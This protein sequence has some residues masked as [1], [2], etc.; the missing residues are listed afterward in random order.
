MDVR[1]E[2]C[3]TEYELDASRLKPG[4]VTVKCTACG[5]MFKVRK[6][7]AT[8][9]GPPPG[10]GEEE[11]TWLVRL[12]DGE[13]KTCRELATLQQ[14]IVAREVGRSAEI[15]RTGKKWKKLGE[16]EELAEL[17]VVAEEARRRRASSQ[18]IATSPP[19]GEDDDDAHP[20]QQWDRVGGP[21]QRRPST[22]H[23]RLVPSRDSGAHRAQPARASTSPP[24]APPEASRSGRRRSQAPEGD[25]PVAPEKPIS[26]SATTRGIG[27]PEPSVLRKRPATLSSAPPASGTPEAPPQAQAG[28]L[29]PPAQVVQRAESSRPSAPNK[30]APIVD[31]ESE[32]AAMARLRAASSG[33]QTGQWAASR[34]PRRFVIEEEGPSGPTGG[35]AR[36]IPT[37]DVAFAGSE[38]RHSREHD[39]EIDVG[40]TY[41]SSRRGSGAAL[42]ILGASLAVMAAAGLVMYMFVFREG[43]PGSAVAEVSADAGAAA[44]DIALADV[45]D[46]GLPTVDPEALAAAYAAILA[47]V[48]EELVLAAEALAAAD[49]HA[50]SVIARSRV[51]ATHAQL[52]L[53]RAAL[54]GGAEARRLEQQAAQLAAEAGNLASRARE[55]DRES[56]ASFVATGDALRVAGQRPQDVRRPLRRAVTDEPTNLDAQLALALVLVKEGRDLQARRSLQD[57]VRQGESGNP[58]D[59]RPRLQLALLDFAADDDD[60]ARVHVE[61]VLA[62]APDHEVARLLLEILD[63]RDAVVAADDPMPREVG[64]PDTAAPASYDGLLDRANGLAERGRC[65]EAMGLF[66]RALELQP[67]GVEALTGLGYCHLD[68][69]E[70]ASAH[71]RFQ[72]ALAVSPRY[73][74]ALYG[75]AETYQQ[76][77]LDQRAIEAYERYLEM[78]PSGTRSEMAR[79]QIIRLGGERETEPEPAQP[80]PEPAEP[81]TGDGQ[82]GGTGE[83][84]EGDGDDGENSDGGDGEPKPFLSDE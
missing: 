38:L 18:R 27:I 6:R 15:S 61:R 56:V 45:G 16:I 26:P 59:P 23:P 84:A 66:R 82:A 34:E 83:T 29:P 8:T 53:D 7:P 75:V 19:E 47:G 69:R 39:A 33:P 67:S 54:E 42:W 3:Q 22:A 40:G 50:E 31:R 30:P 48:D 1:C 51:L 13:I 64:A 77:G 71:A 5:H 20:T 24:P 76:Q 72:A 17:F 58:A 32:Q 68:A 44:D 80:A 4:G 65:G 10:A 35:L 12:E 52:L 62:L 55:L 43:G 49:D 57:L 2:N 9:S 74:P 25:E 70:F 79:R 63:E 73:Q 28:Q 21:T 78:H 11:R 60:A 41:S 37:D 46:G 14:W 36:G 81:G